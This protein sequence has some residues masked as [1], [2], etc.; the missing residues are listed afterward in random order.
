SR[1]AADRRPAQRLE[2]QPG[3]AVWLR[4]WRRRRKTDAVVAK[5]AEGT[6]QQRH[7]VTDTGA[8]EFATAAVGE[9]PQLFRGQPAFAQIR[10]SPRRT[11]P[12]AQP[13]GR[14]PGQQ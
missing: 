6:P 2:R 11:G 7:A 13:P 10:R 9:S 4:A 3:P 12:P 14:A 1:K 5:L 8:P